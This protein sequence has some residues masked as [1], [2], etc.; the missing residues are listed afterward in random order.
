MI[1]KGSLLQKQYEQLAQYYQVKHDQ[2]GTIVK[3][4]MNPT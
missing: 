1:N 3:Y 4:N 2:Q